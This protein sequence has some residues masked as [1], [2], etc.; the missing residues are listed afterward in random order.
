VDKVD[1]ALSTINA[2]VSASVGS[3]VI[4]VAF[5]TGDDNAKVWYDADAATDDTAVVLANL[6]GITVDDLSSM[7]ID[8]FVVI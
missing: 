3:G 8:N 2:G 4:V 5:T 6:T 1:T 7:T